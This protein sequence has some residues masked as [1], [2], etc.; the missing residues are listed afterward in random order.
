MN[1]E[2][3]Q[4]LLMSFKKKILNGGSL[5]G[6]DMTVVSQMALLY[7]LREPRYKL[8]QDMTVNTRYCAYLSQGDMQY[9]QIKIPCINLWVKRT[10]A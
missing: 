6:Y 8:Y 9:E 3:A 10:G 2:N 4:G 7:P 5:L 1:I